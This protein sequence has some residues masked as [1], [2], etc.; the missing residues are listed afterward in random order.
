MT[1]MHA[2]PG[3]H[4]EPGGAI[5]PSV[6]TVSMADLVARRVPL[7]WFE[8]VAIV[9]GLCSALARKEST[10]VP[11]PPD[12]LLSAEGTIVLAGPG[13]R[14]ESDALPRVLHELLAVV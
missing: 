1:E 14:H 3:G 9:A 11:A 8:S 10:G 5:D 12:I 4:H 13:Q 2:S 7:E 6:A